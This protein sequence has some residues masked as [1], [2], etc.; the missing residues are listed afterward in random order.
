MIDQEREPAGASAKSYAPLP[1]WPASNQ[2]PR[3]EWPR[4][5]TILLDVGNWLVVAQVIMAVVWS[6]GGTSLSW[7]WC[8]IPSYA[9]LV[10]A[11]A[12]KP[13]AAEEILAPGP[14]TAGEKT[15]TALIIVAQLGLV[16]MKG[17]DVVTWTWWTTLIPTWIVALLIALVIARVTLRFIVRFYR[18]LFAVLRL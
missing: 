18:A 9:L 5:L 7:W 16:G 15:A 6:L 17:F 11:L 3:H 4:W 14:P 13:I 12:S 10:I 2:V 1:A 8:F